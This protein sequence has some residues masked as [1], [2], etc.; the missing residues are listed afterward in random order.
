[1]GD[2]PVARSQTPSYCPHRSTNQTYLTRDRHA[3]VGGAVRGQLVICNL[4]PG[5]LEVSRITRLDR[6]F[7]GPGVAPSGP[8][9][10]QHPVLTSSRV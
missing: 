8:I 9:R 10:S 5:L 7:T 4:P 1:M 3:A 2:R 6:I